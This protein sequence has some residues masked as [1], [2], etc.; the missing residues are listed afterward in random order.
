MSPNASP[1]GSPPTRAKLKVPGGELSYETAGHGPGI[2]FLH[3]AIADS[4]LWDRE[5]PIYSETHQAIRFDLR[6]YGGSSPATTPFSYVEDIA[7]LL[8]HLGVHKPLLVGSS[9]GGAYAIDFALEHPGEVGGLLL[10]APGLSGGFEP[11]FSPEEQTAF[12]YDD[13]KSR[14]VADEW[15]KGDSA[16]AF[17]LLRQLWCQALEGTSLA[18]FRQMVEQNALEVFADRSASH[19]TRG[20]AA[21]GR[22]HT[23]KVPTTLLAG[24]R[25]NP[26]MDCFARRIAGSIAGTHLVKVRGA[27]HLVNLSRPTDFD[28]ALKAALDGVVAR[29]PE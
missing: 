24:D 21:A 1:R 5:M 25:D 23:I 26:S 2:L 22:L 16:S 18:L 4:R 14:E 10:V 12:D 17:E 28:R 15:S 19:A 29:R 20:P 3:S 6:G 27:D 13:K 7:A 11:P 9:M 8:A